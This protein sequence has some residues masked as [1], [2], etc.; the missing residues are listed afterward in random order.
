MSKRI[1]RFLSIFLALMVLFTSCGI[2]SGSVEAASNQKAKKPT[3]ITLNYSKKNLAVK[4]VVTLKVQSVK[5]K[6]AS[7]NVAWS[8]SNKKIAT[9]NS[10]G[11][12][13]AKKTGNVTITA[14][15]KV[16]K[17]VVAKCKIK[18]YKITKTLK[19]QSESSYT[20]TVG[21]TQQL[22]AKVTS[23]KKG[24]S[25][26]E[27]SSDNEKIAK[28]STKGL[29]TAVS[30]GKATIT[31]KSGKK[32]VKVV[33]MVNASPSADTETQQSQTETK[34]DT[35]VTGNTPA[36][37]TQTNNKPSDNNT[38]GD[39][40]NSDNDKTNDDQNND[41][42]PIPTVSENNTADIVYSGVWNGMSWSID[43]TGKLVI[44][45][46]DNREYVIE[47]ASDEDESSEAEDS[48]TEDNPAWLE[49][50]TYIKSVVVEAKNVK[51]TSLWFSC[52]NELE[53][54]DL[55]NFD[56]SSVTTMSGMF[57]NSARIKSVDLS[58]S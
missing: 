31:A 56:S 48:E 14:K 57:W 55:S 21:Q 15:S 18:V 23:P 7:K 53:S 20:L 41:E 47:E 11:K 6:T 4:E 39:S 44:A 10:K 17:K 30:E 36:D 3:K 38:S 13:T 28:V 33:I 32:K 50:S 29:V 12:V 49:Y 25:P 58:S 22:S 1:K 5:P 9:V 52:C 27:W 43:T 26:I 8:T 35:S 34:D 40:G 54:V 45:G 2:N 19:L 42:E 51:S 16:N 24:A 46:T 37:N